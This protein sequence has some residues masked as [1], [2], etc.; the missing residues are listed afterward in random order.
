ML[1]FLLACWVSVLLLCTT[2]NVLALPDVLLHS[3]PA[4]L[5]KKH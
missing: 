4:M 1:L 5:C 2:F 3:R